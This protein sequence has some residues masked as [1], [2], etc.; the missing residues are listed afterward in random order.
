[1]EDNKQKNRDSD[2]GD[3]IDIYKDKKQKKDPNFETEEWYL[4]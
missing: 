2:N 3:E 1:M 4:K